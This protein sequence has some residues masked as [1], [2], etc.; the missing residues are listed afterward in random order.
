MTRLA[1]ALAVIAA[2]LA[3]AAAAPPSLA[4]QPRPRVV[5]ALLPASTPGE[6][7]G[8]MLATFA[9]QPGLRAI[10][11]LSANVGDYDQRQALLDITQ[12]ARVPRVDYSPQ[13]P[14]PLTLN[15]AGTVAAW[16][17]I[18]RRARGPRADIEPGL[19]AS[20]I[21][22]GA[23]YASAGTKPGPDAVIAAGRSGRVAALSLGSAA[24]L[25]DR[26]G[27]LL[28]SHGLVV[29]D[30]PAG[31]RGVSELRALLDR[32]PASELLIAL[33]QPPASPP[34]GAASPL[35]LAA[36]VTSLGP[37]AGALTSA[38]TRTDHSSRSP[39]THCTA[40]SMLRRA[41]GRLC[42]SSNPSSACP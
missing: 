9:A 30:L 40:A 26:V 2:A 23:A 5:V 19:L 39:A 16:P 34:N 4:S 18:V 3:A 22:G 32:R 13:A 27:R 25:P 10:G 41:S 8:G 12:S 7:L 31:P 15:P 24:R 11:L 21:P 35:L 29:V 38:T 42:R 17:A 6:S 28:A 33:Q 37:R 1:G 14:P 20:Q 36:G